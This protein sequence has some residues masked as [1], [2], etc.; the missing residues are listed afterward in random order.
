MIAYLAATSG[1]SMLW[2]SIYGFPKLK[3]L[4]YG[5]IPFSSITAFFSDPLNDDSFI[6]WMILYYA[7]TSV[8]LFVKLVTKNDDKTLF[9][10]IALLLYGVVL[11]R[12]P[13]GRPS[14]SDAIKIFHPALLLL[15]LQMDSL[16]AAMAKDNALHLK[17]GHALFA[18]LVF[19]TLSIVAIF[20]TNPLFRYE[21]SLLKQSLEHNPKRF[22]RQSLG[23][24]LPQIERGGVFYD[25]E[26]ADS[27]VKIKNFLD[28]YAQNEKYVYFFPNEAVYYFLFNKQNPTRYAIAYFAATISQRLELIA[29]LERNR[30]RYVIYSTK[31][32]RVDDIPETIQVPEVVNYLQQTYGILSDFGGV[33][34]LQRK[35][36]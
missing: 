35:S 27:I 32:W 29:D 13:L 6:Y 8:Y 7:A 3:M 20:G 5:S 18:A 1:V 17:I 12:I 9:L 28:A 21:L 34:V 16:T 2:D 19:G 24:D 26:I 23:V 22:T 4:G 11:L 14:V 10:K 36:I 30:P 31:T 25:P 15:A 33:V